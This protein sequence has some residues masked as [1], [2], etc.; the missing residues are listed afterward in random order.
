[1]DNP[2]DDPSQAPPA[3]AT[4]ERGTSLVDMAPQTEAEVETVMHEE[5]LLVSV[6]YVLRRRVPM[7]LKLN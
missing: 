7:V 4:F 6:L 1:M 2:Y 3:H 5:G